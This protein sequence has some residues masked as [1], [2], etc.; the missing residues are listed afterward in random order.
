M[1][2]IKRT[3]ASRKRVETTQVRVLT[4]EREAKRYAG[5]FA[6]VRLVRAWIAAAAAM[7]GM[8][9][10]YVTLLE[11]VVKCERWGVGGGRGG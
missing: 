4:G 10:G 5:A 1:L 3:S 8:L 6:R 7:V 11:R 2:R 9:Y